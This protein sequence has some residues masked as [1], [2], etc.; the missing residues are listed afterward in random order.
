VRVAGDGPRYHDSNPTN[1]A[2]SK[3]PPA[4]GDFH[5]AH[6]RYWTVSW[7]VA[8]WE[9]APDVAAMVT[10]DWPLGV[11]A[12]LDP[13]DPLPPHPEAPSIAIAARTPTPAS[14]KL[15]PL[16]FRWMKVGQKRSANRAPEPK[17]HSRAGRPS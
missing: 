1:L 14:R 10:V 7:K 4:P 12:L 8:L 5:T 17:G 6:T 9:R 3:L 11:F 13:P 16:R 2:L 15:R